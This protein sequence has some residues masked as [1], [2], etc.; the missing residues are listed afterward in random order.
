VSAT[1]GETATRLR[2][3]LLLTQGVAATLFQWTD[4]AADAALAIERRGSGEW[5]V[6]ASGQ[7]FSARLNYAGDELSCELAGE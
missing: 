2:S 1:K 5:A 4:Q 3:E 7:G 6:T